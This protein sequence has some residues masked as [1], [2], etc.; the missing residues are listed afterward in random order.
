[1]QSDILTTAMF[2]ELMKA[3]DV[4]EACRSHCPALTAYWERAHDSLWAAQQEQANRYQER[5]E[6]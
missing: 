2:D 4:E 5:P 1:M 6:L 3:E